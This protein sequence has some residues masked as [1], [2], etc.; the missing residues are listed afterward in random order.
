MSENPIWKCNIPL[1]YG[2]SATESKFL[3][4]P[5]LTQ[6]YGKKAKFHVIKTYLVNNRVYVAWNT[7]GE[8][9][10]YVKRQ[11]GSS[12]KPIPTA[13]MAYAFGWAYPK[14]DFGSIQGGPWLT[15]CAVILKRKPSISEGR[16]GDWHVVTG[17]DRDGY[18]VSDYI[19]T[20]P[21]DKEKPKWENT[22]DVE[23]DKIGDLKLRLP[24]PNKDLIKAI[25]GINKIPDGLLVD[26]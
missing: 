5:A 3:F 7:F 12:F 22:L 13:Q 20:S 4:R 23:E 16:P 17:D 10:E 14:D 8:V 6:L 18:L 24:V 11:K 19:V 15:F 26:L 9:E 1:F 2:N 21:L 25:Y